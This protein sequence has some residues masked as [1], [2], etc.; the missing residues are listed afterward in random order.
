M[1]EIVDPEFGPLELRRGSWRGIVHVPALG[2]DIP[3]EFDTIHLQPPHASQRACLSDFLGRCDDAFV[4]RIERAIFDYAQLLLQE[5]DVFGR[6][7]DAL[8]RIVQPDDVWKTIDDLSILVFF[9]DEQPA[10]TMA[11]CWT[12]EW[13]DEH[14]LQVLYRV[15][16]DIRA[17][18]RGDDYF[19][20]SPP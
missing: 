7:K 5:Q 8:D 3:F 4:R 10:D 20:D 12:A 14:G 11:L 16:G 17:T 18:I 9:D 15:G 13:E 19:D 6:E 1:P 2:G